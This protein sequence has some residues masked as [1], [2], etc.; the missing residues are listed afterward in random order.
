L[1]EE[2]G[3]AGEV[4]LEDKEP[5]IPIQVPVEMEEIQVLTLL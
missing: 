1:A 5:P 3:A 2:R 4:E